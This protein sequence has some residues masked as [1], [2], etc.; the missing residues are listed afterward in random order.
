MARKDRESQPGKGRNT[1]QGLGN[2]TDVDRRDLAP[3]GDDAP[4][5]DQADRLTSGERGQSAPSPRDED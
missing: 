5:R 1:G 3:S 2:I 4:T